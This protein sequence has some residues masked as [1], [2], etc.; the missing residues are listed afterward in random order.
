VGGADARGAEHVVAA[1]DRECPI[2]W[3]EGA[4]DV[5]DGLCGL[6]ETGVA[7]RVVAL[8]LTVDQPQRGDLVQLGGSALQRLETATAVVLTHVA[9]ADVD[10]HATVTDVEQGERN[11]C[12]RKF[13][14]VDV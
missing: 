14:V 7:V 1:L 11:S 8:G 4:E 10:A 3:A 6:V 9:G 2:C 5:G 12:H 13:P